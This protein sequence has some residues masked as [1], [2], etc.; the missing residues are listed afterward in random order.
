MLRN[1]GIG[2][3]L[4]LS[5]FFAGCISG[6]VPDGEP[7]IQGALLISNDVA[8]ES[9]N[10]SKVSDEMSKKEEE[11]IAS[12]RSLVDGGNPGGVLPGEP[13]LSEPLK[14]QQHPGEPLASEPLP[15]EPLT[16]EPLAS[17]PLASEPVP[18]GLLGGPVTMPPPVSAS[19]MP[20]VDQK[21]SSN[22]TIDLDT[23]MKQVYS[24]YWVNADEEGEG[25]L[26]L[27]AESR[28]GLKGTDLRWPN[29]TIPFTVRNL[30]YDS[31]R[32]LKD[33]INL[34]HAKTC[35]R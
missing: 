16:S 25:D 17:E 31:L 26:L 2:L 7:P 28:N 1:I 14:I 18:R 20:M 4:V 5:I 15:G 8:L 3:W 30:K 22:D 24:E 10:G 9:S 34:F 13:L 19:P 12:Q 32:V 11:I 27:S 35:I 29:R 23:Y 33:S 6:P 21:S